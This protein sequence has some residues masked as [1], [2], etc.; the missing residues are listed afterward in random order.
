MDTTRGTVCW[1]LVIALD[2]RDNPAG[3]RLLLPFHRQR[4]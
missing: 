4:N 3:G 2:P 1:A